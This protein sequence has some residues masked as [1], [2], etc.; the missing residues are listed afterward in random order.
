MK[1]EMKTSDLGLATY[2]V[3]KGALIE[4]IEGKT[5]GQKRF[6]EFDLKGVDHA[7]VQEYRQDKAGIQAYMNVRRF[8][9]RMV[10]AEIGNNGN[11]RE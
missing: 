2:L 11:E 9:L 10:H 4:N 7:W 3:S 5:A 6:A 8:L 1:T